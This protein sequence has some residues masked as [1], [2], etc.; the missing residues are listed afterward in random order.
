MTLALFTGDTDTSYFCSIT[1]GVVLVELADLF[2]RDLKFF[3][4]AAAR[5]IFISGQT[6]TTDPNRVAILGFYLCRSSC[7]MFNESRH[8]FLS[9]K[10][11]VNRSQ[12]YSYAV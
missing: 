12:V 9:K 6:T 1:I 5:A 11:F 2:F 10:N 4:I 7:G 3:V 8:N